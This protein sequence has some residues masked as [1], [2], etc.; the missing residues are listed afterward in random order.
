M[1]LY[2][3]VHREHQQHPRISAGTGVGYR[4]SGSPYE[5]CDISETAED[6]PVETGKGEVFPGPTTFGGPATAQNYRQMCFRWLLSDIKYPWKPF[7]GRVPFR[8]LVGKL[9]R[10]LTPS[11]MVWGRPPKFPSSRSRR[12]RNEVVIG[13]REWFPGPRCGCQLAWLK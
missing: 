11:R 13:P 1:D 2:T 7:S 10:R 3:P 4:I 12:L 8:T 5:I 6:R 9:L